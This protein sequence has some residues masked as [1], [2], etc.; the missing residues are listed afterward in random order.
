MD[1][2]KEEGI[3]RLNGGGKEIQ[4]LCAE[5]DNG[6]VVDWD[7]YQNPHTLACVLKKYYRETYTIH[8]LI[9]SF[10]YSEVLDIPRIGGDTVAQFKAVFAKINRSTYQELALLMTYLHEVSLECEQ[11][12]MDASNLSR[13]FGPNILLL[14]DENPDM[15]DV[16]KHEARNAAI[17]LLIQNADKIFEGFQLSPL[18]VLKDEEIQKISPTQFSYQDIANSLRLRKLR[19]NSLIPYLPKEFYNASNF[20]HP[21]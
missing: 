3:F 6:R 9:P 18:N 17:E 12:K 1:A 11:N 13:M 8:P 7:K 15:I 10:V 5:L 20:V 16:K 21:K 19:M 2:K 4:Q 14:K